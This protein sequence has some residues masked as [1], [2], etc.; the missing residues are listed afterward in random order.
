MTWTTND[1]TYSQDSSSIYNTIETGK[2]KDGSIYLSI[3]PELFSPKVDYVTKMPDYFN[4][5]TEE[6][7]SK[8][9]TVSQCIAKGT[10]S[11]QVPLKTPFYINLNLE[12]Y[13]LH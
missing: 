1:F 11:L 3:N 2:F 13:F 9:T 10:H 5:L 8:A 12:N 4:N 6:T 7:L